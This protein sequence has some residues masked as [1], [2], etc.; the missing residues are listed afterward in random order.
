MEDL[1]GL[2]PTSFDKL[3]DLSG[4]YDIKLDPPV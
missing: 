4:K 2:Y 1:M 3:E